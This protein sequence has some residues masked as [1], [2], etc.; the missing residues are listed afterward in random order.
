MTKTKWISRVII[1]ALS[2]MMVVAMAVPTFAAGC[3]EWVYSGNNEYFC[4][5][6]EMCTQ[7][8]TPFT[9]TQKL[10]A[11]LIQTCVSAD[12]TISNFFDYRISNNGCCN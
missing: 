2:M 7:P 9:Y 6:S 1:L 3:S 8:G 12:G 4:E 5:R 10:R 11:Q